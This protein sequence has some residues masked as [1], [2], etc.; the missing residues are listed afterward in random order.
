MQFENE[1]V[2]DRPADG[3][4]AYW[5]DLERVPER[6]ATVIERRKLSDGPVG[7]GSRF[8]ELSAAARRV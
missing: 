7:V 6:A 8:H 4:F 2:I 3:V 5:A 1:I